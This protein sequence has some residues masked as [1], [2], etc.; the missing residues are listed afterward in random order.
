MLDEELLVGDGE[1]RPVVEYLACLRPGASLQ[2]CFYGPGE[3]RAAVAFED[4]VGYYAV[5]V[6][7]VYEETWGSC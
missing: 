5:E 2:L 3:G 1:L 4:R 6:L 7:G